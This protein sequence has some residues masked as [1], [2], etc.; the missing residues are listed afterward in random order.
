MKLV[1]LNG[2]GILLAVVVFVVP[3]ATSAQD[4][5]DDLEEMANLIAFFENC[6]ADTTVVGSSTGKS[7]VNRLQ[8]FG[9]MLDASSPMT[10]PPRIGKGSRP[11]GKNQPACSAAC[12]GD[13]N[14]TASDAGGGLLR[15]AALHG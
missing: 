11:A 1:R 10:L 13:P 4:P 8:A 9:N 6:V 15:Q 3:L 14:P 2:L 5:V 12:Y 7:T